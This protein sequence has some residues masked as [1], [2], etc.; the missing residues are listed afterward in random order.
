[1]ENNTTNKRKASSQCPPTLSAGGTWK[2]FNVSQTEGGH[3]LF[4]FLKG[5][6]I[7]SGGADDFLKVI[8]KLIKYH[9]R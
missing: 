6:W 2:I 3:A 9:I 4:E 1:M 7:F 5:E 8:F